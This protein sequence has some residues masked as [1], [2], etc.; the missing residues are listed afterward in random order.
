LTR[1]G[2]T[3]SRSFPDA[4]GCSASYA[5]PRA[6]QES[7]NSP[8]TIRAR[9][10]RFLGQPKPRQRLF[11]EACVRLVWARLL[12]LLLPFRQLSSGFSPSVRKAV[13]SRA[14]REQLRRDICW[15]I[16]RA[17]DCLPGKTVCFPRGIAA[18]KMCRK[19]GIGTIMYYGAAID[20]VAGLKAH[21]WVQD[22]SDGVVGH[23]IAGEYEILARFPACV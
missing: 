17:S 15:A 7:N 16:E 14:E 9:V 8:G 20:P 3:H 5:V 1:L 22:G 23:L 13:L 18:Q 11:F 21:V 4:Q 19:R 6:D 12:L 2:I 10:Q